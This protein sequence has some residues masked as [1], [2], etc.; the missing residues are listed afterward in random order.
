MLVA[1][2]IETYSSVDLRSYGVYRY[3]ASPDFLIL[4]ACWSVDGVPEVPTL[5]HAS[6][7]ARL[8]AYRAAGATF[9]AHNAQFERVCFTHALRAAAELD[10]AEWLPPAEWEDTQALAA[11]LGFP[12]SLDKLAKA[13]GAEPK[14]EAGTR[15][16]NLFCKPNRQGTRTLPE[17]RPMEW[18]DFVAY[19]EQDV[20][21]LVDVHERL[22]AHGS[23]PTAMERA[24]FLADQAINDRGIAIDARLARW[25]YKAGQANTLEQKDR[26]R[27][28]TGVD[29]P[30]SV[31]QMGRWAEAEG[32]RN[33]LPD[34]QAATVERALRANLPATHREVLELRQELALAAPAKF[35]T[36]LNSQVG[37]RLR[38]TLK[39]FGA[40]TGRWAGRGTQVQN[41]PRAAFKTD[42]DT[43]LAIYDL[44]HC[45]EQVASEELKKLVRPMFVG[46]FTVVDYAAI[47]ARVIAWL[48][49]EA[50]ALEAFWAG[51][52]IYVETA[53]RMGGLTRAQGKIA[54]LALG[55]NGGAN[56]L[57]AMAG[58][59]DYI[60]VGGKDV[61]LK[62][63][64]DE[65]LFDELVYP[66]RNANPAICRLW[67]MLDAK[68]RS[69]GQAGEYL[70]FEKHG[71]DRLLRLPSGRAIAYRACSLRRDAEGRERLTFA[72][73]QGY[74]ADTYG[75][76]LAENATQ[77]VARDILAEAL[78]RLE[79]QGY[80]VVA[81]VHDEI[82]VEGEHEVE[83]IRSVMCEPP[84]WA[85]GLPIG[86][87][88]FT[89]YRYRKG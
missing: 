35:A 22:L 27:E 80:R 89:T 38:G 74:R 59:H 3:A 6:A 39:F 84:T 48:A 44:V 1:V 50:W 25:A 37:G 55:Y 70:A 21:T 18:L 16:I 51:R 43:E 52:D 19:C 76:R 78:V 41:L 53:E 15:L 88:G 5:S 49:G 40:H 47:E 83:A 81:H 72:S 30:G 63:L 28:L 29:N 8:L 86:G 60:Q 12:Q 54:V 66:W 45:N 69:G 46:P 65:V 24:V 64:P 57:R 11:E 42:V 68:F 14:D 67:R 79:A 85:G 13:L 23:W 32:I 87:D 31:Q 36:A 9:V 17:D 82:L 26:V 4:M 2:D 20:D 56:S 7:V 77:A 71:K 58:D 34:F 73:P 62:Q 33:L 75:G 61:L 10:P